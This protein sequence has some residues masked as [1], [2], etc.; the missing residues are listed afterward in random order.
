MADSLT[1]RTATLDDIE[2]IA[3][4]NE[5]MARET[6]DKALDA[7]TVRAGVEALMRDAARGFY[8]VAERGDT[9]VGSLMITTEWSDWR[10]GDFWWVQSVYVR[11]EA[12]RQGIYTAL[13][14]RIKSMAA[15]KPSVCGVR[16]YVEKEN[17]AARATYQALGM[18]ETPYRMYEEMVG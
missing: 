8:L 16:L 5:A 3:S 1:I 4:F 10:N 7:D 14:D 13:Y 9:V 2:T 11:P 18:K 17:A 15:E 6:E 12:R